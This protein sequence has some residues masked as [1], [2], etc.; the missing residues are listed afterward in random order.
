MEREKI[1]KIEKVKDQPLTPKY[2]LEF[3]L[4]EGNEGTPL[5]YILDNIG[6]E[7]ILEAVKE[8]SN[9]YKGNEYSGQT[10][11]KDK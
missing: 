11:Y 8:Y 9:Q 1:M 3:F 2:S 5:N 6:D 4:K 10:S 7:A